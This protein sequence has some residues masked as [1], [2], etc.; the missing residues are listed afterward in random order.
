[1]SIVDAVWKI[2]VYLHPV[3]QL[4]KQKAVEDSNL[5]SEYCL[6]PLHLKHWASQMKTGSGVSLSREN[7]LDS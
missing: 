6:N 2:S 5:Q 7:N 3:F 1:M 4:S